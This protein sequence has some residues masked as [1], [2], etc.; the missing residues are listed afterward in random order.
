MTLDDALAECPVIAILRGVRPDEIA[1][2]AEALL[3]AGV[4]VVEVPLN[5]P[6]APLDSIAILARDFAGRLVCGGG[7]ILSTEAVDAV[8]DAGGRI[9]VAPNV[10]ASV[11]ARA[12]ERKLQPMPGFFTASEALAAQS[13]GARRLKLF[14]AGS[15]SP[16]H[17]SALRAVLDA[18]AAIFPVGGVTA[19]TLAAWSAAGAVGFGFGSEIYRP[20]QAPEM[21]HAHARAIVDAVLT[22]RSS[23][24]HVAPQ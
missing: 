6:I 1:A 16:S 15:T 3:A 12:L 20:G 10:D 11:I 5:S 17:I 9:A 24:P 19:E 18:G 22:A 13:A 23:T 8:A 21:T 2:H 7:T 4:R 14:P